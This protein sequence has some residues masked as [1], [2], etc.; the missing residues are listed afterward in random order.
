MVITV[1][2]LYSHLKLRIMP[3]LRK[4]KPTKRCIIII[5]I[6]IMPFYF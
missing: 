1:Y 5:I 3:I 4:P 6:I 2:Q